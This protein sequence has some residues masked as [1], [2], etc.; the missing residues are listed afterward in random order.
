MVVWGYG[1]WSITN[2]SDE[3]DC[4]GQ[5]LSNQ[6]NNKKKQKPQLELNRMYKN[7]QV[8][9]HKP[10]EFVICQTN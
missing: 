4:H 2:T 1:W 7:V 6:N 5:P 10:N 3:E 8:Q 9:K